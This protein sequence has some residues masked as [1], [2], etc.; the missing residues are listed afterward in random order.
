MKQRPVIPHIGDA[1]IIII[2]VVS[3][4]V[5]LL[6][7]LLFGVGTL[8]GVFLLI[9]CILLMLARQQLLLDELHEVHLKVHD[10]QEQIE[11]IEQTAKLTDELNHIQSDENESN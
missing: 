3:I 5:S 1:K 11:S 7:V 6:S 10:L 2:M 4:A 8:I 9:F